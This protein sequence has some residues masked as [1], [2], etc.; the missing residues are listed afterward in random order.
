M[1]ERED[2]QT[3]V[4]AAQK[5]VVQEKQE[6]KLK[7]LL[8]AAEKTI[9]GLRA[10]VAELTQELSKYSSIRAQFDMGSLKQENYELRQQND[11]HKAV[12]EQNGLSHL[13]G[14]RTEQRQV[15]DVRRKYMY[16]C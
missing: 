10:K 6:G 15:R 5:F 8:K 4:T 3:L 9:A 7:K 14:R 1:L 13:L 16:S 12:I 2:Y 11:F